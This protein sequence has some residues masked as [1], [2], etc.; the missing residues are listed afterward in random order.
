MNTKTAKAVRS[1]LGMKIVRPTS[2]EVFRA[3]LAKCF[4]AWSNA[5]NGSAFTFK[6]DDKNM[7]QSAIVAVFVVTI[8]AA[9][10][11]AL[12][13]NGHVIVEALGTYEHKDVTAAV[14]TLSK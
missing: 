13:N 9:G 6:Y 14:A 1:V 11:S 2:N 3:I 8:T 5:N 4:K 12:T 7:E 10:G